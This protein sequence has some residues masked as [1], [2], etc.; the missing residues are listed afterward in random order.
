[1][2]SPVIS[3]LGLKPDQ[4]SGETVIITGAGGGIGFEA[5]RALLW[6]GANVIIAEINEVSGNHAE[7][8]LATEFEPGR[9][10]FVQTDV[11]D[12]TSVQSLYEASRKRFGKVDVV[13]NNA[14]IATLG[15]VKDC[16]RVP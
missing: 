8:L 2:G 1:M 13:I 6:L 16:D 5:A 15:M 7:Q 3:Q 14:T 10:L 9:V 12:E 11:G 4:L